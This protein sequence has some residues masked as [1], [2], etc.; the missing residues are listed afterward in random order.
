M[1][2]NFLIKCWFK[3]VG[4]E[5][6]LV[7]SLERGPFGPMLMLSQVGIYR[8]YTR[9]F[10]I[11]DLTFD[12]QTDGGVD[13]IEI[14]NR[15]GGGLTPKTIR[16]RA[17]ETY[18]R[19]FVEPGDKSLGNPNSAFTFT[20]VGTVAQLRF[21][22]GNVERERLIGPRLTALAGDGKLRGIDIDLRGFLDRNWI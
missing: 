4:S 8:D 11:D 5:G 13:R 21:S 3:P 18:F 17:D 22:E 10:S 15:P 16:P 9:G 2:A 1:A 6:P 12:Q 19:L 14:M 20:R 7:P